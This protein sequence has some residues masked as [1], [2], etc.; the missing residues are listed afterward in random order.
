MA[1]WSGQ[2]VFIKELEGAIA[3]LGKVVPLSADRTVR[4]INNLKTIDT[5][6]VANPNNFAAAVRAIGQ[7]MNKQDDI[8]ILFV[9]SHGS[10][11]GAVMKLGRAL[12]ELSPH[13]VNDVLNREQI[14]NRIVIVSA[15]YSGVYV[16]PLT[17]DDTIVMTAADAKNPSFG[18]G[19]KRS[20]TYFGDAFFNRS[21][22]PG[23]SLN[24]AFTRA[25]TLIGKWEAAG[26]LK[27]SNPQGRFGEAMLRKVDLLWRSAAQPKS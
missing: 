15:C 10:E 20:W 14:K 23:V 24:T 16:A 25:R 11:N 6:P 12:V 9:T 1:G 8:L 13:V 2:D 3:S 27:P 4:L 21:L 5:V 19:A 18:C 17:N 26:K 22:K 7:S